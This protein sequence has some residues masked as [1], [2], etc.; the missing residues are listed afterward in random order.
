MG[1]EK[2]RMKVTREVL[3]IDKTNSATGHLFLEEPYA[4]RI[5]TAEQ[6]TQTH[7][8]GEPPLPCFPMVVLTGLKTSQTRGVLSRHRYRIIFAESLTTNRY[9][10]VHLAELT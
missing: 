2:F 5:H 9:S 3:L 6:Q 4:L 10:E 7:V 1:P 8:G